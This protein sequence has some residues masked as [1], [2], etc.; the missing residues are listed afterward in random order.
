MSCSVED[1]ASEIH[2]NGFR[3]LDSPS[4]GF[5]PFKIRFG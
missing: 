4:H 3:V 2:A 1:N 5:N